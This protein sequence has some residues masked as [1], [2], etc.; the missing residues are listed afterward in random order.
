MSYIEKNKER[1]TDELYEV[2]KDIEEFKVMGMDEQGEFVLHLL[3][4]LDKDIKEALIL[5]QLGPW[6]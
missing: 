6:K 5:I 3:D 4:E 1:L 2:V